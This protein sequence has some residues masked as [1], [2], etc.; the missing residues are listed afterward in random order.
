M[1][2]TGKENSQRF[3]SADCRRKVYKHDFYNRCLLPLKTV[4]YKL[5]FF[6]LSYQ[7]NK[8]GEGK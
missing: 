7:K 8:F 1:E 6:S 2:R 5:L 4:L 3:F